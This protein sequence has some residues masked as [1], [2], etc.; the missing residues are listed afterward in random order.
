MHPPELQNHTASC[1][2]DSLSHGHPVFR[3]AELGSFADLRRQCCCC[4]P[5]SRTPCAVSTDWNP[6]ETSIISLQA[7]DLGWLATNE[8]FTCPKYSLPRRLKLMF[9]RF[10]A[11]SFLSTA[12]HL[13]IF[14]NSYC[15]DIK[16]LCG[17]A[18]TVFSIIPFISGGS[19]DPCCSLQ[20]AIRYRSFCMRLITHSLLPFQMDPDLKKSNFLDLSLIH[21]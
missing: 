14:L 21:I 3:E 4:C 16:A 7:Q 15:I 20:I 2:K 11:A 18:P 19:F 8:H 17:P 10:A 5:G 12:T 1:P 6:E 13:S 9:Y